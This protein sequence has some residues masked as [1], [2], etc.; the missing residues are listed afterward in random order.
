MA[1][2][3]SD[4]FVLRQSVGWAVLPAWTR[5]RITGPDAL[6]TADTLSPRDLY[7][8]DGQALQT[9]LLDDAGVVQMDLYFCAQHEGFLLLGA[10]RS[11]SQLIAEMQTRLPSGLDVDIEDQTDRF[12]R[13]CIAGPYAWELMMALISPEMLGIQHLGTFEADDLFCLRTGNIGE[14]AYDLL[15]PPPRVPEVLERLDALAE[16]FDGRQVDAK[17]FEVCS[18]ENGIFQIDWCRNRTLTA[19]EAQLQWRLRYERPFVGREALQAQLVSTS[20]RQT[21]MLV[22]PTPM[23]ADDPVALERRAVG[24]ILT[25]TYSPLRQD[26]VAIALV[27]QAYAFPGLKGLTIGASRAPARA[28]SAPA[29]NNRSLWVNPQRHSVHT[30]KTDSF[31]PLVPE[32]HP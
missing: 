27:D 25:V 7:I 24:T 29:I 5:V 16:A 2:L 13:I 3:D 15:L 21:L 23:Q 12:R 17:S 4:V 6:E 9:V 14:Y 22:S 28:L 18:I 32:L 20:R 31:A 19:V 30:R 1:P 8:R 10:G 26:F 11:P